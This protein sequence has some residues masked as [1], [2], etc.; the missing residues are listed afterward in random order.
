MLPECPNWAAPVGRN[1]QGAT[2]PSGRL[3]L[4]GSHNASGRYAPCPPP[5]IS[6]NV[7]DLQTTRLDGLRDRWRYATSA[8]T[9]ATQDATVRG[10]CYR[11]EARPR[12]MPR[13]RYS[14]AAKA[15]TSRK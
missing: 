6:S 13:K 5:D 14:E 15:V 4:F 12:G 11:V 9:A 10:R 8:S 3:D 1:S 7:N 2:W